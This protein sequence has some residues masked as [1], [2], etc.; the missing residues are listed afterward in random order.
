MYAS[1]GQTIHRVG[2]EAKF[3][4]GSSS[5]DALARISIAPSAG[6]GKMRR[7]Q[8]VGTSR[9]QSVS[10]ANSIFCGDLGA[11]LA[12]F[13]KA[14]GDGLFAA[15]YPAALT[16]FAGAER[17]ALSSAHGTSHRLTCS[18]TVPA[19]RAGFSG[20]HVVLLLVRFS[21]IEKS[22]RDRSG[23]RPTEVQKKTIRTIEEERSSSQKDLMLMVSYGNSWWAR[24]DLNLG[25]TDYESAA[26]TS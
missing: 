3:S 19:A 4:N 12:R 1:S 14:D 20:C 5:G 7:Y 16:A 17:A 22:L 6:D 10:G 2:G 8:C 9:N 24:Q 15:R 25:P 13:R 23:L 11:F 26:L 18:F 21:H